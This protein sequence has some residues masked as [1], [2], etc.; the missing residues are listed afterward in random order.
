MRY[1]RLILALLL[2]GIPVVVS[3]IG[4]KSASADPFSYV[5]VSTGKGNACAVSQDGVLVCWG[6]N[7][8]RWIFPQFPQGQV[9][10]PTRIPLPNNQKWK[11]VH[12]GNSETICGLSESDRAWCWGSHHLGNYFIGSSRT[13]VEVEFSPGVT[14]SEVQ[15]GSY[16]GCAT[17]T[18]TQQ[19]W[20]WG[21][22]HY[23]GDGGIDAVRTPVHI[24]MPDNAPI[25]TFDVG[26]LGVCA[27]TT[28]PNMYC[29]G[30][31]REGELGLGF[32]QQHHYSYSW[33]PIF[34]APPTGETWA[35]AASG[36]ERIC[37]I[38][39]SGSGYCSGRNY[40]GSF[41]DGT[42]VN[43]YRFTKMQIPNNEPITSIS[44][45]WYHTCVSTPS[46]PVLCVGRGRFGDLGTG[47]TLTG[48][49]WRTPLVPS[50]VRFTTFAAGLAGTC[51][52][53]T[54][55]RVWCW[56]SLNSGSQVTGQVNA[57]L[58]P[59]T[60]AP[61]GSPSIIS[62]Q[63]TSIDSETATIS[64]NINPNGYLSSVIVEISTA[65]DFSSSRKLPVTVSLPNNLYQQ[66]TFTLPINTLEPRTVHYLRIIA[67][68]VLGQNTGATST[69]TT[70]GAEPLVSDVLIED[71]TGN[72][73]TLTVSLNAQR[74]T[75]SGY[76][77]WSTDSTF[78]T[79]VAR[80]N[81]DSFGGNIPVTKSITINSLLPRTNYFVR[82][83]A[84]NRLG[85]TT[86][87]TSTM[88]TIGSPPSAELV[89]HQ[90]TTTQINATVF[91]DTG[92]LAG[93][94]HL[95]VSPNASFQTVTVSR[96]SIFQSKGPANHDFEINNLTPMT[97]YWIRAVATNS[98]GSVTTAG[99]LQRTMGDTPKIQINSIQPDYESA[100][101]FFTLDTTGLATFL[102]LQISENQD[103]S[104]D[105]EHFISSNS[106]EERSTKSFKIPNLDPRTT[107]FITVTG[108]NAAGIT[109]SNTKSLTTLTP[110]GVMINDGDNH[111]L[112]ATVSL[113]ITPPSPAVA[114]RV[115]NNSNF[116][117]ARIFDATNSFTWELIAST[118]QETIRTVYVEIYLANG[119]SV[120]YSDDIVLRTL[121]QGPDEAL[122]VISALRMTKPITRAQATTT[123]TSTRSRLQINVSDRQSGVTKIE[124]KIKGRTV[125]K[126]VEATR[127]GTFTMAVPKGT[128]SVRIR[129]RDAAGNYSKWRT[130][131][132]KSATAK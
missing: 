5:S 1:P 96:P 116:R 120:I 58:F 93:S 69:F 89:S 35:K 59:Q 17:T 132:I 4:I 107:Y 47:T 14:L 43:S 104:Q 51:A 128:R 82:V 64:G 56:G 49:I 2:I 71:I 40:E 11:S 110:A 124:M 26:V 91:V 21:D 97:N 18:S 85:T 112:S 84:T 3:P 102:T 23:L 20:C 87:A 55:G 125:A 67:T 19:L 117:N 41:G 45:G 108:R 37:A 10:T 32:P 130:L 42:T 74:L 101:V 109:V 119:K 99:V 6:D 48:R 57:N 28:T 34:I 68:N 9:P 27:V 95:E 53:D 105:T 88:T 54:Q 81:I 36:L 60:I 127:N 76:F 66:R 111:T 16:V 63:M 72:E 7:S 50:D 29:W 12:V 62:S 121:A 106:L 39:T 78:S 80:E 75:T 115:S 86:G 52:L 8:G 22:A 44:L 92:L 126:I 25:S 33:T 83:V 13:P 31:N 114:Y 118:E 79:S 100:N 122:P 61:V 98:L 94:V 65:S 123:K 103:M 24:P 77:E 113:T 70:L 129:L 90:A 73:A 131:Q 15:S 30:S 38:T 46:K